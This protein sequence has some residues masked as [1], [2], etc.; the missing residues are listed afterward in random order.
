MMNHIQTAKAIHH[1]RPAVAAS[2]D[3]AKY[4]LECLQALGHADEADYVQWEHLQTRRREMTLN[5]VII[6]AV[7][8]WCL[9]PQ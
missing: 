5:T 4:R 2:D 9:I 7:G 8:P 6:D 1:Q 3:D